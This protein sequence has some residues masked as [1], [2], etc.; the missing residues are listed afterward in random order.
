MSSSGSMIARA[1]PSASNEKGS[2]ARMRCIF[3]VDVED[4]FHILDL[5]ST[6]DL[7]A[8]DSLPSF[9]ERNFVRLLDLVSETNT[10]VTCFFLGWVAK[11]YPQLVREAS[12]LGHE[13]ASHGFAHRLIYGMTAEEFF[14]DARQ[15]KTILDDL[16]GNECVGYRAAGFSVTEQTPWFFEK[17]VEAGYTYDSSVFPAPRA[18]GGMETEKLGPHYIRTPAGNLLEFPITVT[19]L[20]GKNLCF[21]GG[22]YLRL[23]PY[24]LIRN[25]ANRVLNEQRP[26]IFY[27]HP[28]E[29]DPSH[30]R[31]AMSFARR[32]KSYV[33]LKTTEEKVRRIVND[34]NPATFEQFIFEHPELGNRHGR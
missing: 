34:F 23:T 24:A 32:F 9:V 2:F 5:P 4:W 29:I 15:T 10:K 31:L 12:R 25:R 3:S 8:W 17:L 21:F 14:Q 19:K 26:V 6:P 1:L 27:V 7:A 22:G 33:N 16:T 20:A 13:I 18:H 11:K 30:P 28:R